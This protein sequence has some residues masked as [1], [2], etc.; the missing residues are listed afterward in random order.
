MSTHNPEHNKALTTTVL[1]HYLKHHELVLKKLLLVQKATQISIEKLTRLASG[2]SPEEFDT[3]WDETIEMF[4]NCGVSEEELFAIED[5]LVT[6]PKAIKDPYQTMIDEDD[7]VQA[8][9][10]Q[11]NRQEY[12]K[13][14][15]A[16]KKV[17]SK[18]NPMSGLGPDEYELH[19]DKES[20][21]LKTLKTKS[22]PRKGPEIPSD[23]KPPKD[24]GRD[25][26][27]PNDD[28]K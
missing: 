16:I 15:V 9:L 6:I 26:W 25:W 3:I 12:E 19:D 5:V 17:Q 22:A 1:D 18:T 21:A 13:A 20:A 14:M 4:K 8:L 11:I 10:K 27:K 28:K 2:A 23:K 24:A 7:S